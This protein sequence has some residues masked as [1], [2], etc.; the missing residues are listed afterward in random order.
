ME[1]AAK[2]NSKIIYLGKLLYQQIPAIVAMSIASIIPKNLD[3][4][5]SVT[6]FSPLK[7]YESMA[8][9]V[10]VIVTN[11]PGIADIVSGA[12]CGLVIPHGDPQAIA[13][14]IE[15]LFAHPDVRLE[16]GRNTGNR[17]FETIRGTIAPRPHSRFSAKLFPTKPG[18]AVRVTSAPRC[19]NVNV[20]QYYVERTNWKKRLCRARSL[21]SSYACHNRSRA[22]HYGRSHCSQLYDR[23]S[24]ATLGDSLDVCAGGGSNTRFS[25]RLGVGISAHGLTS[26]CAGTLLNP[27]PIPPCFRNRFQRLSRKNYRCNPGSLPSPRLLICWKLA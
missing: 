11:I 14:A 2:R 6:S 22:R 18:K 1:M 8:C 15:F 13:S 10:P 25:H 7:V 23:W 27:E 21:R 12:N 24:R 20:K 16:L 17:Q 19:R 5:R 9:G 4:L 3:G 26:G